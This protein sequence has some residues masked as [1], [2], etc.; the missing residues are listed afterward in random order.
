MQVIND[1]ERMISILFHGHRSN[2]LIAVLKAFFD[3]SA[4]HLDSKY[5]T[6]GGYLASDEQWRK[7]CPRWQCVLDDWHIGGLHTKDLA[8]FHGEFQGWTDKERIPFCKQLLSVINSEYILCGV[9]CSISRADYRK[10]FPSN[11]DKNKKQRRIPAFEMCFTECFH[12]LNNWPE[13]FPVPKQE[14]AFYLEGGSR[15]AASV[16]VCFNR[17]LAKIKSG[18]KPYVFPFELGPIAEETKKTV[19][20]QAADFLAY[21]SYR[22]VFRLLETD[23]SRNR[24]ASLT[25]T[26]QRVDHRINRLHPS[27][28]KAISEWGYEEKMFSLCG[29]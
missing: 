29:L 12:M 4:T 27:N 18:E 6:V 16:L 9:A 22:E 28:L 8:N 25:V 11:F 2:K 15:G 23:L 10:M 1:A 5:I 13:K 26:I 14:L 21:E 17:L 3:D 19:P 20:L 7:F 24:H